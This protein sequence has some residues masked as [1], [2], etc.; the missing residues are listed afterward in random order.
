MDYGIVSKI[1]DSFVGGEDSCIVV[2]LQVARTGELRQYYTLYE[3]KLIINPVFTRAIYQYIKNSS[4]D[5]EKAMKEAKARVAQYS[6]NKID[7]EFVESPQMEIDHLDAFGF[8]WKRGKKAFYAYPTKE[9][10]EI[11][12]TDKDKIKQA[13]F[14]VSKDKRSDQFCVF[15]KK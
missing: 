1:P 7:I 2:L 15:F 13:G 14:W 10:W 9:F 11:W 6:N 12:K 5:K 8:K 3:D 4:F